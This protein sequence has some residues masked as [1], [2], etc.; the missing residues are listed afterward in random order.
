MGRVDLRLVGQLLGELVGRGVL[1]ADQRVGVLLAEQV[2]P[3]GRAV[4]QRAAGEDRVRLVALR[5][6]A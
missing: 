1:V 2:G 5:V 6:S 3:A 4:E